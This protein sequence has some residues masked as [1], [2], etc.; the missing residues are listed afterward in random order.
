MH[1]FFVHGMGRSPVSGLPMLWR[2]RRS[3]MSASTFGYMVSL[4][5][6]ERIKQRLLTAIVKTAAQGDYVVIGHSL[7]GV[8]LRAALNELPVAVPQPRRVFLLGSPVRASRLAQ[9]LCRNPIYRLLT[10]ECGQ[11]LASASLMAE[12]GPVRAPMSGIVGVRGVNHA[13]GPFRG[14]PNDGVV[15]VSEVS[16]EWITDVV[17]LPIVHTLLPASKAVAE[18]ILARI[19]QDSREGADEDSEWEQTNVV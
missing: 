5:K 11:L 3:G 18:V 1:A 13:R 15:S 7:G 19:S 4:E 9:K 10:G 17:S 16:A 8:L 12:L 6:F 2:L 14:E